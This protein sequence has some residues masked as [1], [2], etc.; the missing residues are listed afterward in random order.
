MREFD[1]ICGI[2][3]PIGEGGVSIIRISGSKALDIISKIFVGKNNIDLKQMKTY[4]MRYGHIIELESKDVIDEVIISYMKGPHSYTTEDIIEI[5]CHGGVISTNSV[6]NQVIKAGAR[7]AEP[8][9]FTKRAFLNGRIDLSQAEAVIDIIKAKTDL[10]MKSALM[11]SGGALSMQIKEIRQYLLNTLA[12]IEYGVDFTEDD[13][14]IDDTLVLRVKD[15]IKTT[16]LKVKELLKGADEGKIIRDGLNV[17]IIG[18]PNVGKSSLLNVLLKE[19]RAIVTDI[20]GTTRDIIEE[21]L[22]IDGIPIKITDTAGIRETEDTVEK[23]GVERSRE[24]IEEAD[25]IILI[26]DSSRDLEEEDK[27]I[28]NTIKD[29]NHIVL[30]NKTDLDRKIVD[31]DLDNQIKISAKTGYGIEELKN[32]IKEL[33]FSGDIN[34]ESLIVSNVRHKQALYRSLENC[35]VALDRVNANEFLDLISIYVTSAMKALGEITGDELE[36]DVLNKIFSEFC[37]G[38]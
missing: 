26:L 17:V 36:E 18:K 14:D 37:V 20:P 3:T 7:V 12:L 6:M 10:S 21:Y 29:K 34:S 28:I 15:G 27:E 30:L 16:I 13:E 22:N 11:Q 4:T 5:N 2:A 32:K 23:I 19:K 8:G 38:K 24:K 33:F 9:E 25:L 1:T 31:I 35:E